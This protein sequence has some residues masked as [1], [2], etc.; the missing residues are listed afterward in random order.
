MNKFVAA[1]RGLRQ[2]AQHPKH[3]VADPG[4]GVAKRRD[5]DDN[6]HNYT[7]PP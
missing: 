3:V 6:A 4:T 1:A 7:G 2:T 5:V